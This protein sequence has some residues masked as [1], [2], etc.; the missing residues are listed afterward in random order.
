M[1]NCVRSLLSATTH[2]AFN[3]SINQSTD[4]QTDGR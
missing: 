4:K 1:Q 3:Q 2:V